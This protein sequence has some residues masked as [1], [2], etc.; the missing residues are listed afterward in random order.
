MSNDVPMSNS[1]TVIT[2]KSYTGV[3]L[4]RPHKPKSVKIKPEP[5]V[6]CGVCGNAGHMRTNKDCPLYN[7][8]PNASVNLTLSEEEEE[9]IDSQIN[10][11][12]NNLLNVDGTKVTLSSKLLKV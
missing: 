12:D 1:G 5:K 3:I 9:K 6:K 2:P 8:N 11:E 10:L 4:P 7:L